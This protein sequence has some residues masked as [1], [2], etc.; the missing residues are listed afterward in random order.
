METKIKITCPLGHECETPHE[1]YIERCAWYMEVEGK[2]PFTGEDVKEWGCALVW[3]AIISGQVAQT[4]RG[5]TSV[6]GDVRNVMVEYKENR[7]TVENNFINAKVL[8]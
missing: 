8:E 7:K 4:N 2:H 3:N 5:I 6:I 1:G